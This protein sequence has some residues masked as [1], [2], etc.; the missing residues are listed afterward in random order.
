[1]FSRMS[2]LGIPAIFPSFTVGL[3]K[4]IG[5]IASVSWTREMGEAHVACDLAIL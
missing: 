2:Y 4:S 3:T 5:I 1:M